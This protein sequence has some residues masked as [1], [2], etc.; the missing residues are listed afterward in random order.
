MTTNPDEANIEAGGS[1][2]GGSEAIGGIRTAPGCGGG[3]LGTKVGGFGGGGRDIRGGEGL[4][5]GVDDIDGVLVG[6]DGSYDSDTG[7]S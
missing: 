4:G 2:G 1:G 3:K 6:W 5:D 7:G